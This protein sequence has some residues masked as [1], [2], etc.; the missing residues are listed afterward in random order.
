[1]KRAVLL[2]GLAALA[3]ACG[4]DA[5]SAGLY[6]VQDAQFA[7]AGAG[8]ADAVAL[9]DAASSTSNIWAMATDW[10]TCVSIGD[11]HFELRTYKL[12]RVQVQKFDGFWQETRQ[13]CAVQNTPLL[14]QATVF[15]PAL[16]ASMTP[17]VVTS[18]RA[19]DGTYTSALEAQI[20]GIHME[21]PLSDPMPTS[22]SDPRIYDSDNDGQPAATLKVGQ[23]CDLYQVNRAI[24]M[25]NGKTVSPTRIEG[26]A[27]HEVYQFNIGGTSA[28]CTTETETAANQPENRFV[29]AQGAAAG[30]DKDGDGDVTCAEI[31]AGQA[32]LIQWRPADNGRCQPKP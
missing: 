5:G 3:V 17:Q 12:L 21:H 14:G 22:P 23:M 31:V 10:S 26:G 30:L 1:M 32:S 9:A 15:P 19:S 29:L 27:V 11:L 4:P 7:D 18:A 8:A 2:G 6:P 25:L 24:A 16:I 28:F 20:V 13:V